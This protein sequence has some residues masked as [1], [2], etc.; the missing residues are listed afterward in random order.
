[1]S[2]ANLLFLR[3]IEALFAVSGT[4]LLWRVVLRPWLRDR[5]LTWDGMF[6]LVCLSI[7][8]QDPMDNYFNFT[9]CYNAN[10]L[11]FGSWGM[12]LP[13]WQ[14]PRQN[15]LPEPLLM[16]GGMF[17]TLFFGLAVIGCWWLRK[18][19]TW[20]PRLSFMAH[21]ALFFGFVFI[22]DL[23]IEATFCY[24]ELFA[25]GGAFYP[26]TLWAGKSY[27]FPL[28]ESTGIASVCTG[29]TLMRHFRDDK[30]QFWSERGV[31]KLSL[32]RSARKGVSFL[33]LLGFAHLMTFI[34]FFVPYTWFSLE[35]D[36]FPPLRSYLRV[37]ICGRGTPYA[38]PSREVPIPSRRS[39]AIAPDDARLSDDA[40]RN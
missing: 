25:Y 33:A 12:F 1:M 20:L 27:Q 8:L 21:L 38:C 35:A 9:F 39:L 32:P 17:I 7:Y 37:E 6:L 23:L 5:Q 29:L 24:T 31:T 4:I 2:P 30:G 16:M 3:S 19:N 36:S 40:R 15:L 18:A 11:N 14:S 28:Y 13:G 10:L 26:L 22:V 34:V